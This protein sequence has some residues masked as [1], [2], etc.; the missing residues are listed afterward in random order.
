[1]GNWLLVIGY[2][3]LNTI[4]TFTGLTQNERNYVI[5]SDSDVYVLRTRCANAKIYEIASLHVVTVAM[6][7][8]S[9]R[10]EIFTHEVLN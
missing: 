9:N 7:N 8:L 4:F 10:T 3:L 2:W 6:T 1:M 5:T